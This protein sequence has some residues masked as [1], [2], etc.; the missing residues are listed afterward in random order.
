MAAPPWRARPFHSDWSAQGLPMMYPY[1][2]FLL[3]FD[4]KHGQRTHANAPENTR[5]AVIIEGRPFFFLPKVI[6]NAMFFLG[7]RW[8]LYVFCSEL[9][10]DYI[11]ASLPGWDIHI[12][13][14]QRASR[15]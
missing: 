4:R 8:N 6:K 10:H 15:L 7:P 1:A 14:F 13:K 11:Q 5:A 9:S 3:D 12:T 2:E